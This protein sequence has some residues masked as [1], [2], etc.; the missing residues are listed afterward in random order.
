MYMFYPQY[1]FWLK[2][3]ID[4]KRNRDPTNYSDAQWKSPA[5]C[6]IHTYSYNWHANRETKQIFMAIL[7]VKVCGT[8]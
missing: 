2:T 1:M 7:V 8:I 4:N 3:K 6:Y 5:Q